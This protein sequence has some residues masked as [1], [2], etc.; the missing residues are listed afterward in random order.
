MTGTRS[1]RSLYPVA[2]RS[3]IGPPLASSNAATRRRTVAWFTPNTFAAA[4]T[5]YNLPAEAILTA[6]QDG[7]VK[8]QLID[9]TSA[10]VERGAFGSPTFYVGDEIYFGKE[11]LRDI[12]EEYS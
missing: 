1:V 3:K 11:K 7:A 9:N 6:I 12:E 4:L 5:E 8:Q 2:L 10:V